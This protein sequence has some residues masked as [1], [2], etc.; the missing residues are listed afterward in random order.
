[1]QWLWDSHN[2]EAATREGQAQ[3]PMLQGCCCGVAGWVATLGGMQG[4]DGAVGLVVWVGVRVG[5]PSAAWLA[6]RQGCGFIIWGC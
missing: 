1:M 3:A 2:E 6:R 4:A 5:M